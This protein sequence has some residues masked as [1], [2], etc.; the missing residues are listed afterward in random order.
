[1]RKQSLLLFICLAFALGAQN[2]ITL[3]DLWVKYTFAAAG[4]D[5]EEL[6]REFKA[7]RGKSRKAR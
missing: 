1:M 3:E 5:E 4:T 2:K 7:E 6:A